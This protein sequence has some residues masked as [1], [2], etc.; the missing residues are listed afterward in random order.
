MPIYNGDDEEAHGLPE[1]AVELKKLFIEHDGFFIAAPEYN[2]SIT[3][4]LKNSLDWV[5][6]FQTGDSAQLIAYTGKIVAISAASP[7]SLGGLRGLVVLRMMLSNIGVNVIPNQI[8][9]NQAHNA[10]DGNGEM[11]DSM[12]KETLRDVVNQLISTT[13]A[14]V[15]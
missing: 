1:K 8:A 13:K 6:R 5:S 12:Q 7:G 3:P 4:L 2:S 15:G 10:F 9:I 14:L 11:L